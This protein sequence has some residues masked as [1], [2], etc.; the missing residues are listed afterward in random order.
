[1]NWRT[2]RAIARKDLK[3]VRQNRMAWGPMI[4][5]PIIFC[6]ILPLV[7]LVLPQAAGGSLATS[8]NDP[9]VARMMELMLPVVNTQL[10]GLN[11]NQQMIV[12][13][14]GYLFAPLFLILPIMTASVV[15]TNSFV[16]EK[17]RKTIEALLYTPATDH[18]LFFGKMLAAV[19]LALTITWVSFVVYTLVL[20]VAGAPIME[21]IWFPTPTWLPLIFWVTPA[22]S[23]LGMLA[24]VLV[25][26]RVKTFME[27][28]QT[29]GILVLPVMLLVIGQL[30]GVIYLSVEVGIL[31]G[32][33]VWLLDGVLL[34]GSLRLFSR[35]SLFESARL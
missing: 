12:L 24:A 28:Y 27:A 26:A 5:V 33:V 9:D 19:L 29:T 13:I 30:F 15:G 7:L 8:L 20:N 18:E 14:L 21:R 35:Y 3:E 17:E 22:V 11:A 1:M 32:C 34:W 25:S 16:G 23:V 31:V 6:I 10:E 4:L 2:I